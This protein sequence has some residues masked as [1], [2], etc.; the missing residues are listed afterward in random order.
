[1]DVEGVEMKVLQGMKL[2]QFEFDGFNIDSR[3]FFQ[4]FWYYFKDHNFN[5][6]RITPIGQKK[7]EVYNEKNECFKKKLYCSK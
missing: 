2:I 7:I 3:T 4:D 1:M 6:F 5:L